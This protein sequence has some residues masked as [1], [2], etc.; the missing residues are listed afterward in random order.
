MGFQAPIGE[1]VVTLT[2]QRFLPP[3]ARFKGY[4][5]D[6]KGNPTF[7]VKMEGQ[8]LRDAFAPGPDGTLVRTLQLSG[9]T[10]VLE[11][12]LGDNPSVTTEKSVSLAPGKP[13]TITYKLR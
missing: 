6:P 2:A 4:S 7:H 8:L 9:G 11:I 3:S 12:P 10:S 5:L 13:V 1:N